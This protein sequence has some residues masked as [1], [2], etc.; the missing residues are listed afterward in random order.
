MYTEISIIILAMGIIFGAS[1]DLYRTRSIRKNA[2]AAME[3]EKGKKADEEE[4]KEFTKIWPYNKACVLTII[5]AMAA[6]GC[7]GFSIFQGM[8]EEQMQSSTFFF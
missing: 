8:E 6:I 4:K 1:G 3:K 5:M 7:A 2:L